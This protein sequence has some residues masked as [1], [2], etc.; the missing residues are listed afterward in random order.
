MKD[1]GP[2]NYFLGPQV[3][4]CSDGYYLS[5]AKYASNLLARSGITNFATAPTL[6][7]SNGHLTSFDGVPLKD[8]TLYRQLVGSLIY[9]TVTRLDIVYADH[10]VSQ[11]MSNPYTIHFTAALHILRY[12]K[13]TL[14]HGLQFSS[15]TSLV[16]SGYSDADWTGDPTDRQS[17]TGYCFLFERFSHL[18]AE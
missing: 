12:V 14:G 10:I 17:T 13:D 9:L 7:D 1:L 18:L 8:P 15:K 3:L 2:L 16:M 11:F 5:Q 4:S 6:L